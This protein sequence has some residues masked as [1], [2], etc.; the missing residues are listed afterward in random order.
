MLKPHVYDTPAQME[1]LL[2]DSSRPLHRR[3]I[4]LAQVLAGADGRGNLSES[5][6]SPTAK[7]TKCGP[8]F[9]CM[10]WGLYCPTSTLP[11]T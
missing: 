10:R 5:G 4:D 9:R 11:A 7:K 3:L 1:P 8:V 6:W 2:I